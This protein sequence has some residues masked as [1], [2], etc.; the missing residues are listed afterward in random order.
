MSGCGY[1][2]PAEPAVHHPGGLGVTEG[3]VGA[4]RPFEQLHDPVIAAAGPEPEPGDV[5]VG[6]GL[7]GRRRGPAQQ[8]EPCLGQPTATSNPKL[9]AARC[10]A[11]STRVAASAGSAAGPAA[12]A[13]PAAA[14][15]SAA[16]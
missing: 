6:G 8:G 4:Q 13:W 16:A 1:E 5:H 10:A 15:T 3:E 2:R 9:A 11:R 7:L 14:I 12:R